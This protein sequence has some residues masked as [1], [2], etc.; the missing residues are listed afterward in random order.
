MGRPVLVDDDL[1]VAWQGSSGMFTNVACVLVEPERWTDVLARVEATVPSG[2]PVTLMAASGTPDLRPHGWEPVGRPPLMVRPAG[3]DGPTAPAELTVTEVVD[4]AGLVAFERIF[5][6]GYPEPALQP[7][8]PGALFD[9]RILGGPTHLFLGTVGGRSVAVA[10][11]HVSA[12]VNNAELVATMPDARGRGYGAAVTWAATVVDSTLPATLIASDV[13][14]PVYERL[15]Y[16]AVSRWSL[17]HR[18]A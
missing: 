4:E 9:V 2:N 18:P 13:G 7:H 3:G 14:R 11:G 16:V 8:R 5:V 17:W 15:G 1:V 10:A 12:G 6:D